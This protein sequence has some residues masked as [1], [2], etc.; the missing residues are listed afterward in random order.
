M[1]TVWVSFDTMGREC[2]EA[3]AG[4]GAEVV[5][6]VTLPGPIDPDRSGQCA[7]DEVA[8]RL[9]AQLIE[10][11]DVNA[12]ETVA[13]VGELDPELIFVVGWSQ[14][15]REPFIALARE[16]VFG[17]HPTLLP[18]HRGRAPIPWAILSGLAR[19]GVTLFEIAD[20]TADSGAIV[21]Q[22]VVE[23]APDETATTLYE[24]VSAAHVELVR[25]C[26]PQLLA[27]TAPRIPQ[28]PRRASV[29]PRRT[30][31]DGIIDWE[32]R[33]R[34]LYDWVRAQTRPYPGAFTW[35]GE[36]KVVIWR[37]RPVELR[38]DAPAGTVV[39]RRPEGPVVACGEGGLVLEEVE[40]TAR[41]L[42]IGARLG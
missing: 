21:G 37:A 25:E 6:V 40:T 27:G 22:V 33:A 32:T 24:K 12:A 34:Y 20:S 36:E 38:T 17:M 39:E 4:A 14:L 11:R 26:V 13:Q 16:G 7:F 18:K 30:P 41:E 2:L 42:A 28:D 3:A 29:W 1:R 31:A 10:T 9:G 19:T 5:G 23:I 15:V 8:A 35:L